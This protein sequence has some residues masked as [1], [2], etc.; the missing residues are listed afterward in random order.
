MSK[1][2]H[3]TTDLDCPCCTIMNMDIEIN[4]AKLPLFGVAKMICGGCQAKIVPKEDHQMRHK[5]DECGGGGASCPEFK[6]GSGRKQFLHA[7]C[8]RKR[9][10]IDPPPQKRAQCECEE[11][12]TRRSDCYHCCLILGGTPSQRVCTHILD[13]AAGKVCNR[14][15][16]YEHVAKCLRN[17]PGEHPVC[18][19]HLRE[20]L[21]AEAKRKQKQDRWRELVQQRLKRA[22]PHLNIDDLDFLSYEVRFGDDDACRSA[23][24]KDQMAAHKKAKVAAKAAKAAKAPEPPKPSAAA[25]SSGSAAASSSSDPLPQPFEET[26]HRRVDNHFAVP[27]HRVTIVCDKALTVCAV[28]IQELDEHGHDDRKC[29]HNKNVTAMVCDAIWKKYGRHV[30]IFF[31]R[32]NPDGYKDGRRVTE[33]ECAEATVGAIR[34]QVGVATRLSEERLRAVEAGECVD[35]VRDSGRCYLYRRFFD[36]DSV[37]VRN[38]NALILEDYKFV[39]GDVG[40]MGR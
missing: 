18:D 17:F 14:M 7:D 12:R 37:Q 6:D 4:Q 13:P 20:K 31:L 2:K 24:L 29:S 36:T 3:A 35:K 1:G 15:F 30:N 38:E 25:S 23:E 33:E 26:T 39:D 34:V 19:E 8:F 22:F 16:D 5:C 27:P 32:V 10:G 9:H 40:V 28:F 21:G 11:N